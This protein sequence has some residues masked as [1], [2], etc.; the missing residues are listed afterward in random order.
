MRLLKGKI[1]WINLE[2]KIGKKDHELSKAAGPAKFWACSLCPHRS[3]APPSFF[4]SVLSLPFFLVDQAEVQAQ[5]QHAFPSHYL[6]CFSFF[7]FVHAR[8]VMPEAAFPFL[9]FFL[10]VSFVQPQNPKH[11]RPRRF[12]FIPSLSL[13]PLL[14]YLSL[15]SSSLG[16]FCGSLI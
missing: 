12:T 13:S 4:L 7:F 6:A 10:F 14:H 15:P 5:M 3:P 16:Q 8:H 9:L 1:N 2:L 11:S